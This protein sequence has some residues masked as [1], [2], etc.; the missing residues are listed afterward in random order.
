MNSEVELSVLTA[1]SPAVL[2]GRAIGGVLAAFRRCESKVLYRDADGRHQEFHIRSGH[3]ESTVVRGTR[4]FMNLEAVTPALT[5]YLAPP[6]FSPALVDRINLYVSSPRAGAPLHFDVRTVLIIQLS[7]TKLWQVATAPA[8]DEPVH[9]VVANEAE[10]NAIHD[11]CCLELPEEMHFTL[12][13]PGDWLLIPRGTWHAT[14]SQRGSVSATLAMSERVDRDAR[15][16]R[17]KSAAHVPPK[18]RRLLC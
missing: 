5:R 17:L 10:N 13:Q 2:S 11:G 9:N 7:G 3:L 15:L 14:C 6:E 18:A 1:H 8:V 4:C 12:L 16:L